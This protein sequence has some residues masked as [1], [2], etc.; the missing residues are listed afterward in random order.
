MIKRL[1]SK[2][3]I[4]HMLRHMIGSLLLYTY[5]DV[6]LYKSNFNHKLFIFCSC[7]V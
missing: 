5:S 1:I 3:C 4:E 7:H 2:G 6:F